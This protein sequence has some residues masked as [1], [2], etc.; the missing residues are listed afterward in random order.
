MGARIS[1]VELGKRLSAIGGALGDVFPKVLRRA[2]ELIVRPAIM[3]KIREKDLQDRGDLLRSFETVE[4]ENG[5][6]AVVSDLEY[7][8]IHDVGGTIRPV[9][10]KALTIPLDN[11]A[12]RRKASDFPGLVLFPPV[13]MR[14]HAVLADV[15]QRRGGPP[16]VTPMFLLVKEVKISPKHYVTE[17]NEIVENEL[18]DFLETEIA[19]HV[20]KGLDGALGR[21]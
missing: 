7:A 11:R 13:G 19:E 2:A 16:K 14:K 15:K 9:K 12:K 6:V 17:A 8:N 10:A 21:A 20:Q 3:R 18:P 1:V 5:D 4:R